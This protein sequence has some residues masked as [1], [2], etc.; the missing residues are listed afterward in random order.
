[1]RVNNTGRLLTQNTEYRYRLTKFL[2]AIAYKIIYCTMSVHA[3]ASEFHL[4]VKILDRN[5]R[6]CALPTNVQH[7]T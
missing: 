1:M 7:F 3:V 6:K 2:T 5:F 4:Y